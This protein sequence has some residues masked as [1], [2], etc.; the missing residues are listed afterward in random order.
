MA[1][2]DVATVQGDARQWRGLLI[3]GAW[4][5]FAS[6]VMILVQIL[7]YIVWPP[8]ESAAGFFQLLLDNPVAG[9]VS[10]DVLYIVSNA[11]MYV[12][13]LALAVVLWRVSRSA[14]VVALAFCVVGIAV[15]M[16]TPRA[17]EMLALAQAYADADAETRTALLATGDGML[18]TWS[19]TGYDIY[20]YLTFVTLAVLAVLM[21]RSSIFSRATAVWGLV[22]AALMT[23][24][25]NFGAVGMAFAMASLVPFSVFAA[26]A[27]RR[28]LQLASQA[29]PAAATAPVPMRQRTP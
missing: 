17:V 1:D 3:T 21:L 12:V 9:L 14:V 5:A 6:V 4:C 18:A 7:I 19:G 24:P 28:L 8:P 13:Y 15:Y 23:V 20:Y 26:L 25:T 2:V 22:S 10:L 11:L 27:G 16:S 29:K